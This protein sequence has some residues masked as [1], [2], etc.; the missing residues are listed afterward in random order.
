MNCLHTINNASVY[1]IKT[2]KL[3]MHINSRNKKTT[4][5]AMI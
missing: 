4:Y 2:Q 3:T 1:R 5:I